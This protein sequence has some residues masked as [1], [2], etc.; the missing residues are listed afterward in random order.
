MYIIEANGYSLVAS[1]GGKSKDP[2]WWT[3]LKKNPNAE[4]QIKNEKRMM[5]ARQASPEEK[6][7]L[8]PLLTKMYPTY[9]NYQKKT[10]RQIPVIILQ[11]QQ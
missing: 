1:N 7:R 5:V 11:P 3:N 4:I 6:N 10:E 9:D 8:W 2:S